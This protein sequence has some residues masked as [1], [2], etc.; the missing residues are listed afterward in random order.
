MPRIPGVNHLRAAAYDHILELPVEVVVPG[1]GPITDKR[2]VQAVRDYLVYVRDEARA[3]FDAGRSSPVHPPEPP[4]D[5]AHAEFA[6]TLPDYG[7]PREFDRTLLVRG[8]GCLFHRGRVVARF[9][10]VL[11]PEPQDRA[12]RIRLS[13]R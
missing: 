5:G 6:G 7:S 8:R 1:H 2:G 11:A 12:A 9:G 13:R 10:D 3:R 4:V